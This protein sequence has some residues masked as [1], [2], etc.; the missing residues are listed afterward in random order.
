MK[1]IKEIYSQ[2]WEFSLYEV[3]DQKVITVIFP[4]RIDY[5]RSFQLLKEEESF[6]KEDH[7]KLAERIKKNYEAYK[8]REITPPIFE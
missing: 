6:S 3:D 7:R 4:D 1:N 5:P 8:S 2:P